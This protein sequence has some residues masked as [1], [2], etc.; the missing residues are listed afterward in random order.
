MR[1]FLSR[2]VFLAV[3]AGGLAACGGDD[4]RVADYRE[5]YPLTAEMR[6][7]A[8]RVPVQGLAQTGQPL[9]E[10]FVQEWRRR[11]RGPMTIVAGPG[12]EGAA[13]ALTRWLDRRLVQA[14][15]VP[16]APGM[17]L[18]A[19][20]STSMAVFF[21]AYVAVVKDCGD[22]SGDTINEWSNLPAPNFGCAYQRN[23]GM[24]LSDPADLIDPAPTAPMDGA[25]AGKVIENYRQG[26]QTGGNRPPQERGDVAD[27]E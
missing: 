19:E 12:E 25:R 16:E 20:D 21:K 7:F 24:M 4:N 6:T 15:T 27:V 11:G 1:R 13:K 22:W 5:H 3:M 2:C 8:L 9:P 10:T 18:G 26:L 14:V 17:D 23:I